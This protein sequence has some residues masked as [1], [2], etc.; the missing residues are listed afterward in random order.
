M[1]A[2][3][4][5]SVAGMDDEIIHFDQPLEVERCRISRDKNRK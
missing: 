3:R 5:T 2:L 4:S 1:E